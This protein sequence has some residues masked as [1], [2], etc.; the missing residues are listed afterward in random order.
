M[1]KG[2]ALSAAYLF[3]DDDDELNKKLRVEPFNP[4]SR[5]IENAVR[6]LLPPLYTFK[7]ITVLGTLEGEPIWSD[8]S[9]LDP[10]SSTLDLFRPF[11]HPRTWDSKYNASDAFGESVGRLTGIVLNPQIP[12]AAAYKVLTSE[13]YDIQNASM[14]TRF[15]KAIEGAAGTLVPTTAKDIA[16]LWSLRKAEPLKLGAEAVSVVA[17]FKINFLDTKEAFAGSI[18]RADAMEPETT[19]KLRNTLKY[20]GTEKIDALPDIFEDAMDKRREVF[21]KLRQDLEAARVLL[22]SRADRIF[23]SEG[24]RL[25]QETVRSIR[26]NIMPVWQMSDYALDSAR[27]KGR[28]EGDDRARQIKA[29]ERKQRRTPLTERK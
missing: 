23:L 21:L 20:G 17:G 18:R 28:K 26:S 24:K 16:K 2:L 22:G 29:L 8:L 9:W 10:Y 4:A 6:E 15:L 11:F 3:G 12:L 7:S 13:D 1:L 19:K 5:E 25:G 14:P 27:E